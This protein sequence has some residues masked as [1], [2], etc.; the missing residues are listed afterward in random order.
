MGGGRSAGLYGSGMGQ[1]MRHGTLRVS[2]MGN[3]ETGGRK[4]KQG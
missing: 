4:H 2:A 1:R 3:R